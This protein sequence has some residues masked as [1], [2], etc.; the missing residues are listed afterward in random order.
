[1]TKPYKDKKSKDFFIREFSSD[2]PTFELVWHRDKKDRVVQA[3]HDTDWM[4]Q[5]DN[6]V[7]KRLSENKLFIPKE[8][9]HRL[10]KGTGN[11]KVKIYEM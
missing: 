10:L 4:F 11:L 8:T 1:M 3:M 5:M 9:Y 6:E 7:P 2:T